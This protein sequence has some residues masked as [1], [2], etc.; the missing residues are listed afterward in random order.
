MDR[1][2]RRVPRCV[3]KRLLS[4]AVERNGNRKGENQVSQAAGHPRQQ[5][6]HFLELIG[7]LTQCNFESQIFQNRR[8]ELMAKAARVVAQSAEVARKTLEMVA[9]FSRIGR[10]FSLELLNVHVHER[11]TLAKVVMEFAGDSASFLLLDGQQTRSQGTQF[12]ATAIQ[13]MLL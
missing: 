6:V 10:R 3:A 7:E 5:T 12:V 1:C 9:P 8:V 2:A 11:K 4:D 13:L